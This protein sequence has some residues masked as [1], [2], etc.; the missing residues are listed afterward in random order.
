MESGFAVEERREAP[1]DEQP[2]FRDWFDS[3]RHWFWAG[4]EEP[5]AR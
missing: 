5:D 2:T 1:A 4:E 3:M